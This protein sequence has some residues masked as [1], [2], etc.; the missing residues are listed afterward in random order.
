METVKSVTNLKICKWIKTFKILKFVTALNA[1]TL[2]SNDY[3]IVHIEAPQMN[4]TLL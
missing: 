2:D 3:K 1:S 4:S